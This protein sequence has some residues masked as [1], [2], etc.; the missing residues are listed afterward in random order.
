MVLSFLS[1]LFNSSAVNS[2][3]YE[4]VSDV[5]IYKVA[6]TLGWQ[7]LN[8]APKRDPVSA[9]CEPLVTAFLSESILN[10]VV[11]VFPFKDTYLVHVVDW[12]AL[13]SWPSSL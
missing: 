8:T 5:I 11:Y 9:S 12:L 4:K 2:Q 10:L 6:R 7:I 3:C 13:D 1:D